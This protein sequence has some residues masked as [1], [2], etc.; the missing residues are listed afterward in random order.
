MT[1]IKTWRIINFIMRHKYSKIK[2]K[3]DDNYKLFE[4]IYVDNNQT[5]ILKYY[6]KDVKQKEWIELL[7]KSKTNNTYS[8]VFERSNGNL[9]IS[10]KDGKI[11]L[12]TENYNDNYINI[13]LDNDK[14]ANA[15]FELIKNSY[16]DNEFIPREI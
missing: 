11:I 15:I 6:N 3:I 4:F 16:K 1:N 13:T 8:L 12:S 14:V 10:T 7:N 2:G 9:I 5:I